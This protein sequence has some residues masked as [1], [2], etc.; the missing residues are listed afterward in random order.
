M[1]KFI[2]ALLVTLVAITTSCSTSD[3][4]VV[5]QL[6]LGQ[7]AYTLA[8]GTVKIKLEADA[9][10]TTT[11]NVPVT[12]S[13][14]AVEG[15]DY[16]ISGK[17]FEL[18]AGEKEAFITLTRVAVQDSKAL[19]V[20]LGAAPQGY[21]NGT[22]SYTTVNLLG[23][24]AAVFSFENYA[25][26]LTLSKQYTIVLQKADGSIYNASTATEFEVEVDPSS[27]AVEGTHFKFTNN[28]KTFTVNAGKSKGTISL[29]FLKLETGKNTIVLKLKEKTGF[30][31]G[32]N[33]KLTITIV[34]PTT[35]NGT[36][37][38]S[39]V[40]PDNKTWWNTSWGANTDDLITGTSADQIKF[41]GSSYQ[42][43]T[44]TPN[45]SGKLKN[46]F[47]SACTA[48]F[49][50][51]RQ[52]KMQEEG[53]MPPR[54]VT[55]SVLKF[56]KI[57]TN[58]SATDSK[59]QAAVVGFRIFKNDNSEEIL[60]CTIYDYEPTADTWKDIY[61]TMKYDPSDPIMLTAPIRVYFK[62]VK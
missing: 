40:S 47:A 42:S 41:E 8:N 55:L 5:P 61:E 43:Y 62:R 1:R 19:T 52:E 50:N 27:T 36:W 13:G 21:E 57:N 34:G 45:I 7:A 48:T 25:D 9:A 29:D 10:P 17:S 24:D 12:I 35:F 23:K 26:Q 56:D 28:V 33:D 30:N 54:E 58:I 15:T 49:M 44:F 14:T 6:N 22:M 60:E 51:E 46:Y 3:N 11:M 18:K 37:A 39:Q 53:G 32:N 38:F 4:T 59:V 16:T 20:T 2:Y 31:Y